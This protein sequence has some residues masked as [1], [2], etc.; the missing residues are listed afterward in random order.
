MSMGLR[1][2]K[3]KLKKR[4]T[5]ESKRTKEIEDKLRAA[6]LTEEEIKRFRRK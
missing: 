3:R 6:G 4:K 5:K 1:R 2:K